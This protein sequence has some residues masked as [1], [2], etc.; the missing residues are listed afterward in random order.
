[1]L[2]NI[3]A[4]ALTA[5]CVLAVSASAGAQGVVD[6]VVGAAE[7]IA[8][9]VGEAG[10]DIAD[11][12]MGT[13]A[14]DPSLTDGSSSSDAVESTDPSDSSDVIDSTDTSSSEDLTDSDLDD[15]SSGTIGGA[16][17]GDNPD[18]GI[19][20]GYIAGAAILGALGVAVTLNK[21]RS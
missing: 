10:R 4:S 19:S 21:R 18:T 11:G 17:G 2:K 9:G 8:D 13:D 12:I 6:G 16:A 1:M 15:N 7:D 5:L 14:G 20:F 3:T